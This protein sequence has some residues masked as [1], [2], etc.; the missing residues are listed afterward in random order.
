MGFFQ[1]L[2]FPPTSQKHAKSPL[3]VTESV[4]VY[5][6]DWHPKQGEVSHAVLSVPTMTLTKIMHL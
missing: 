2:Q 3:G 6:V 4:T 1:V 5:M